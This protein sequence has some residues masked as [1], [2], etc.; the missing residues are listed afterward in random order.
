MSDDLRGDIADLFLSFTQREWFPADKYQIVGRVRGKSRAWDSKAARLRARARGL[1]SRCQQVAPKTG[2]HHCA[3]CLAKIAAWQMG[4]GRE[5]H[6]RRSN[7]LKAERRVEA[8]ANGTCMTCL[9]RP[10]RAK[11]TNC[12]E[13]AK[14]Q[15]AGY[16]AR[17]AARNG[18]ARHVA[19]MER[20]R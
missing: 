12:E 18:G 10:A 9:H 13:C 3:S 5:R 15:A 8:A 19:A 16:R 1:C 4:A 7:R 17:A 2:R 11:R 6:R 14:Q 20:G